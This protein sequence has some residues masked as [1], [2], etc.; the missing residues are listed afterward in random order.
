M[1]R[2]VAI[3]VPEKMPRLHNFAAQFLVFGSLVT[4]RIGLAYEEA[5]A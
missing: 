2:K 1:P 5:A 4:F 3:H